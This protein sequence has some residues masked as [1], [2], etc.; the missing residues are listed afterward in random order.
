MIKVFNNSI[1]SIEHLE[2]GKFQF[3]IYL[4][5]IQKESV[6]QKEEPRDIRDVNVYLCLHFRIFYFQCK[7][8][9]AEK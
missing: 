2:R 4:I 6:Y 7:F 9:K 5:K 1:Q 3:S 8:W